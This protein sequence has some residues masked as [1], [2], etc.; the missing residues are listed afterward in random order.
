MSKVTLTDI[1]QRV[2]VSHSTVSRALTGNAAISAKVSDRVKQTAREMGYQARPRSAV[3]SRSRKT[4]Q[5]HLVVCQDF[6]E[7]DQFHMRVIRG[8]FQAMPEDGSIR[9]QLRHLTHSASD[10]ERKALAADVSEGDGVILLGDPSADVV[11]WTYHHQ[12]RVVLAD[13]EI[14]GESYNSVLSDNRLGG[15]LAARQLLQSKVRR[16]GVFSGPVDRVA[17]HQRVDGVR[18]ELATHALTLE[19]A[20]V[21]V[22]E[23]AT[24]ESVRNAAEQWI[25]THD[26]PEGIVTTS[27]H[28]L[29]ILATALESAGL[30]CPED[31][32]L[33]G[34]DPDY[35]L[36]WQSPDV[37]RVVTFPEQIGR[38]SVERLRQI[39]ANDNAEDLPH[40]VLVPVQL[41]D[42]LTDASA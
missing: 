6:D 11:A 40:K 7:Q 26:L 10:R 42:S 12:P 36:A 35:A 16:I 18:D 2:G 3:S 9:C 22:A 14:E 31:I 27:N 19:A 29:N 1:A 30:R 25:A 4:L 38:K 33:V 13:A 34:F 21:R 15:R 24:T 28:T 20:D 8:M 32:R 37:P 5:F 17:W 41:T 23:Q 39:M